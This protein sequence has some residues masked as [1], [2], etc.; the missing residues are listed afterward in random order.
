MSDSIPQT[1]VPQAA[2]VDAEKAPVIL[3]PPVRPPRSKPQPPPVRE[4]TGS[5]ALAAGGVVLLLAVYMIQDSVRRSLGEYWIS[6]PSETSLG[7]ATRILPENHL[8]WEL[9]G[10]VRGL[11]NRNGLPEL[12][13]A[14][15]AHPYGVSTQLALAEEFEN[16][17]RIRDAE[18]RLLAAV[19]ADKGF[20]PSWSLANFYLRQ[21]EED[22]FWEWI[23]R[24]AEVS[25]EALPLTAALCWR[26]FD[27]PQLILDRGIPNQQF[28]NRQYF[29]F[30][31]DPP[32][33]DALNG[34]WDRFSQSMGPQDVPAAEAF[35]SLLIERQ[36]L[37]R[38]LEV[39]NWLCERGLL[40]YA[41]LDVEAGR[42]LTNAAF[43]A[44]LTNAGFD[45]LP[46]DVKG[47]SYLRKES[48]PGLWSLE[49]VLTGAQDDEVVVLSQFVPVEPAR[50]YVLTFTYSTLSMPIRTGMMWAV[51]KADGDERIAEQE[52]IPNAEGYW[53]DAR[54]N[55]SVDEDT[56]LV[57]L[58]LL[59]RREI[60]EERSRGRFGLRG[61][62][63]RAN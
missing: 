12:E 46:Q 54:F 7:L 6:D 19:R 35:V 23:S 36:R 57:R 15:A 49:Y 42:F 10:R 55:F 24:A 43:L 60:N 17:G 63:L 8:G 26:A 62:T 59:Y 3:A 39:W 16:G 27:D 48:E 40:P 37:D 28:L 47:L 30:L 2:V 32:R 52:R 56:R 45:W 53:G 13:E 18:S 61:L 29:L 4:R 11:R 20:L 9:L 22:R 25:P 51:R 1:P 58:D 41:P 21:G 5:R 14:A 50:D 38:A 44:P 33:L 31:S 34:A